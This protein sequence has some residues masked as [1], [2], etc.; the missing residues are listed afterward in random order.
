MQEMQTEQAL[1]F[2]L[3]PRTTSH[4]FIVYLLVAFSGVL[5]PTWLRRVAQQA[6]RVQ[7]LCT[8]SF[9]TVSVSVSHRIGLADPQWGTCDFLGAGKSMPR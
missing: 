5:F 2:P 6:A 8:D 9:E 7:V 4:P 1:G 3:A